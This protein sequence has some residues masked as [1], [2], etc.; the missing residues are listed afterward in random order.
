MDL[1][2]FGSGAFGIPTLSAL[3]HKHQVKCIVTQPDRPAGRGG[4]PTPTPIAHWAAEHA[5]QILILKPEKVNTPEVV[6]QI[7][8]FAAPAWVVIAFGQKLGK[9]LLADQFAINLHASLLPR[10]RGAAPIHAA[11]L[12]GDT[13]TGNSVITLADRMDAGLVLGTTRRAIPP[14]VTAGEMHD[15][16]AADGPEVVLEVLEKHVQG[17][18]VGTAQDE[19]LVTLASK[20]T[21]ADGY[22]D[23]S[24]TAEACRVRVHGLTPWPGVTVEW[25]GGGGGSGGG[26]GNGGSG[27]GLMVKVLRVRVLQESELSGVVAAEWMQV[28]AGSVVHAMKG[29]VACGSG[30]DRSVLELLE[31]QPANGKAMKWEDFARGRRVAVGDTLL[32]GQ[33]PTGGGGGASGGVKS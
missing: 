10:W 12:G 22:V 31:V 11:I 23:F 27:A 26:G 13:V 14:E 1:V 17:Q 21:K 6:A 5:P 15:I 30:S 9:A 25:R 3:V 16:L 20:F 18:L 4:M 33:S 8:S 24:K 19:S 7:R 32:G 2:Y 28:N 29:W